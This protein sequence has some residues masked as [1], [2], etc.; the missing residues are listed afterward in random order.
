M[1]YLYTIESILRTPMQIR[2][3]YLL[4]WFWI[5]T[6]W[7]EACKYPLL[8]T[9]L[10]TPGVSIT[11]VVT[12]LGL[13][14]SH[15]KRQCWEISSDWSWYVPHLNR[16]QVCFLFVW[17]IDRGAAMVKKR[18]LCDQAPDGRHRTIGLIQLRQTWLSAKTIYK[19]Q[20]QPEP[21]PAPT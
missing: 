9:E 10:Q 1:L 17:N 3:W 14:Y 19:T 21:D 6:A 12:N 2:I 8:N 11:K 16:N 20:A 18:Q 15:S 4:C 7:S 13:N 5:R